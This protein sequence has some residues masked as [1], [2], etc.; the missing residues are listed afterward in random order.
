MTNQQARRTGKWLEEEVVRLYR[1]MDVK[2]V[3]HNVPMDGHQIDVYVEI[4]TVDKSVLRIAIEAKDRGRSVGINHITDFIKAFKVLR[5]NRKIDLG[6]IVSCGG[7]SHEARIS[8]KENN[9]RLMALDD[10]I[11]IA[12]NRVVIPVENRHELHIIPHPAKRISISPIPFIVDKFLGILG[13]LVAGSY[14]GFAFGTSLSNMYI[15]MAIGLIIVG[16]M[17]YVVGS[18]IWSI[19]LAGLNIGLMGAISGGVSLVYVSS[20]TFST[21]MDAGFYCA[22]PGIV[23][24]WLLKNR[25]IE[26]I[27]NLFEEGITKSALPVVI[28]L[29][30]GGITAFTLGYFYVYGV[31]I[32]S[33]QPAPYPVALSVGLLTGFIFSIVIAFYVNWTTTFIAKSLDK[34]H[35]LINIIIDKFIP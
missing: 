4:E 16:F 27:E 25:A 15:G 10:L 17:G 24:G 7:F 12:Q 26:G 31:S 28:C 20:A 11:A 19:V 35:R 23:I 21:P 8:A 2:E 18:K 14:V 1:Q 5:D 22:L 6:I 3:K 32:K 30:T 34:F 29:A 33:L 9:I 13:G